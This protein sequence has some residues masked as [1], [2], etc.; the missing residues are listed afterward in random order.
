MGNVVRP[1]LKETQ[2][3][4]H[5]S[6]NQY[7]RGDSRKPFPQ[8]FIFHH[9]KFTKEDLS[10][11]WI[12]QVMVCF[13]SGGGRF[14]SHHRAWYWHGRTARGQVTR[15]LCDVVHK[16]V[17]LLL[18]QSLSDSIYL[19]SKNKD[20]LPDPYE[21]SRTELVLLPWYICTLCLLGHLLK[22]LIQNVS[23]FPLRY[24]NDNNA[25]LAV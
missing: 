15:C 19:G 3:L 4:N 20:Q 5:T 16:S 13:N 25:L 17:V 9:G 21:S 18:W 14:C 1:C 6:T 7:L 23:F 24:G 12:N 11:M 8:G 22:P 10:K 2:K